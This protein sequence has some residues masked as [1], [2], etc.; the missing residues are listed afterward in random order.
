M[1]LAFATM[2]TYVVSMVSSYMFHFLSILATVQQ[3]H[4]L[5]NTHLIVGQL[6]HTSFALQIIIRTL[7]FLS[8]SLAF[9]SSTGYDIGIW[10]ISSHV[11]QNLCNAIAPS[12][13]T[14]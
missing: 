8:V 14:I 11:D 10:S 7:L 3:I 5:D 12:L 1:L 13:F 9:R 4:E 6:T 2:D